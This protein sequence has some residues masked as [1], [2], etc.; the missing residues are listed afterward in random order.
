MAQPDSTEPRH[1]PILP[2][3]DDSLADGKNLAS[4][5]SPDADD[6]P[7]DSARTSGNTSQRATPQRLWAYCGIAAVLAAVLSWLAGESRLA[8][9]EAERVPGVFMGQPNNAATPTTL[10]AALLK[11]AVRQNL[12]FGGV[13]GSAL[14]VAAGIAAASTRRAVVAGLLGLAVGS[15]TAAAVP[16]GVVPLHDLHRDDFSSDLIPSFLMHGAIWCVVGASA[17]LAVAVGAGAR[18]LGFAKSIL[19]GILGAWIGAA[20]FEVLGGVIFA[21]DETGE[22]IAATSNARLFARLVV[23]LCIAAFILAALSARRRKTRLTPIPVRSGDRRGNRRATQYTPSSPARPSCLR[24]P[25]R[26]SPPGKR[27]EPAN[28]HNR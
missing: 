7:S 6:S 20:L 14:G 25:S 15:F 13:M 28:P 17:G 1:E 5:K 11:T 22:P 16:L 23:G 3:A 4:A 8:W 21:G 19:G 12:V 27:R 18:A 24:A 2:S 10:R 9:V 26:G